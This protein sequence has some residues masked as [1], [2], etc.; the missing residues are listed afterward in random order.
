MANKL[1]IYELAKKHKKSTKEMLDLLKEEFGLKIKSHM[2]V[3]SGEELDIVEEYFSEDK[4]KK[5]V[6]EDEKIENLEKK[7]EK[8]SEKKSFKNQKNKNKK[9]KKKNK[10]KNKRY[11]K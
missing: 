11:K 5:E 3:I 9:D 1:R 7:E 10:K 8:I 6:K 2:S 4:S